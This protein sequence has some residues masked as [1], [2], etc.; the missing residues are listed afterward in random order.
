MCICSCC[1]HHY[2]THLK[3]KCDGIFQLVH[4]HPPSFL[5]HAL[6][7][8]PLCIPVATHKGLVVWTAGQEDK[9]CVCV[10][11]GL[12]LAVRMSKCGWC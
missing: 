8:T 10:G 5:L 12:I 2:E 1:R 6:K 4:T 9:V 7:Q 11:G 3:K